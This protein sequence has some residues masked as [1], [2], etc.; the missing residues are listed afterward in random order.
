MR[1][2]ARLA[3]VVVLSAVVLA[4]CS[5]TPEGLQSEPDVDS[6]TFAASY[7][8]VYQRIM[9]VATTCFTPSNDFRG[10]SIKRIGSKLLS[11]GQD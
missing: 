7:D 8:V 10:G 11:V 5:A 9:Q 3:A 6:Q 2:R 4:G 1:A